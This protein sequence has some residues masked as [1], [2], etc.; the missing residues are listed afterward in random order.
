MICFARQTLLPWTKLLYVRFCP[1]WSMI[2]CKFI[3]K[4]LYYIPTML[5][6]RPSQFLRSHIAPS[7]RPRS[8]LWPRH[9]IPIIPRWTKTPEEN[10]HTHHL[11]HHGQDRFP[12]PKPMLYSCLP[13][14]K[15]PSNNLRY[16][17]NKIIPKKIHIPTNL[18]PRYFRARC[19]C[20][21][22][23]T[24]KTSKMLIPSNLVPRYFWG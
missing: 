3:N 21:C 14:S 6:M 13:T 9:Y 2:L 24:S 18:G 22:S 10:A 16:I 17:F 8:P 11:G 15:T 12:G 20:S 19:R 4:L 5:F 7:R 23:A 1:T